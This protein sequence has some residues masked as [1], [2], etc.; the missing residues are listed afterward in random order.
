MKNE[1]RIIELLAEMVAG[2]DQMKQQNGEIISELKT[3]NE[4]LETLP[5]K[6][7]REITRFDA[8]LLEKEDQIRDIWKALDKKQDKAA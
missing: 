8:I 6:I 4:K 5:V 1:E 2:F 7:G 3:V